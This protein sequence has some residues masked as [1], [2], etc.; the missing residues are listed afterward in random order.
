MR[1]LILVLA[2]FGSGAQAQDSEGRD[3]PGNWRVTHHEIHGI[4]NTMCDE[5]GEGDA[6]EQRCYIRHVDVF[7]PAPDFAAQFVFVT[8]D[9][10]GHK[11]DFG[12]E[13]G[14]RFVDG[15]FR[16]ERDGQTAWRTDR[17]GCLRGRECSFENGESAELLQDMRNGG[18]LWFDFTDRHGTDQSLEWSLDGFD[19]AF[20]DYESALRERGLL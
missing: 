1:F 15:G 6:F 13:R 8:Q 12:M 19:A 17:R 18:A 10:G 16:L 5:R 4:W 14:T 7:S 11:I 20:T 3:T 2:L 9:G